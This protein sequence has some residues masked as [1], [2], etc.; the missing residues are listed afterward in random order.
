[1]VFNREA[2]MERQKIPFASPISIRAVGNGNVV[3]TVK[4]VNGACEVLIDWPHARR[5]P[6]YQE[7]M[8]VLQAALE[9]S[10][11]SEKARDAFEAFAIHAGVLATA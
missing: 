6:V 10:E 1:M 3:R 9:G 5:G 8:A 7:T 2:A 11:S 4:S